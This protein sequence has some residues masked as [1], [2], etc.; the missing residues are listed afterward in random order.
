MKAVVVA[1]YG[2]PETYA[3]AELPVP[4]PGPGQLQV[5]VAA[6]SVNPG[7][8]RLP[9]S[10]FRASRPLTF[11]H[12]PGNDFA[13]TVTAVGSGVAGYGVGDEVFGFAAPRVLRDILG[14]RP[15]VGTGSFAEYVVVEADTPLVAHR[16]AGLSVEDAG[17][18]PTVGFTALA[19][20]GTAAVEPG[21]RVLVVGASGS[22]RSARRR[23]SGT[24]TRIRP[25]WTSC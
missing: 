20:I 7:D 18:L 16:P 3:I 5:R 12:V 21:E 8:I 17:A 10:E 25:M 2:P 4:R 23:S 22:G 1:D 24:T 14:S 6:A 9:G 19:L 11:P 13:G 15:S